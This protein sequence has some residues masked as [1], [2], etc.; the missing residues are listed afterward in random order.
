MKVGYKK[1]KMSLFSDLNLNSSLLRNLEQLEYT[2]PTPIQEKAIP[3]I[4]DG[5]DVIGLA[6]TGTGKTAAFTLPILHRL[7]I[8]VETKKSPRVLI[9]APTRELCSQIHSSIENYALGSPIKSCAVYGGVGQGAQIKAIRDGAQIVVATPGR[10]LDL[11]EQRLIPLSQIEVFVIDEADRMLDMGFID[12]IKDIIGRLPPKR[13]TLL[14]SA[15]MP[16]EIETLASRIL[17]DPVKVEASVQSSV[18][19]NI[20]QKV[21]FCKRDHKYQL[22]KKIIKEEATGL[23][24]VFTRT[25]NT[26]DSVVE[27]LAQNR[28][29][30]RAIHGDKNQEDRERSIRHFGEGNIRILIATDLVSRGIDVEG[31]GHVI[32]FDLPLD[33][34]GYVHRIGRTARA[35]KSGNAISFCEDSD[36]NKLVAIEE[37]IRMKIPTEKFEGQFEQLQ[38]KKAVAKRISAPTPGKSQEKTSWLDHSRR[39]RMTADGK[40]VHVNPAF[41]KKKKKKRYSS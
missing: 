38:L 21:I 9:L 32:N 37:L 27:Y 40:K 13:Q 5:N 24:L 28:M 3:V 34:E 17:K 8:P 23:I 30:S 31:V 36:K 22:L 39:Q 18:A 6:R 35:G 11:L 41:K 1:N 29:A 33:P 12:D 14:F 26:A 7:L 19:N 20:D 15:T 2:K 16:P 4:M 25:K 10:L